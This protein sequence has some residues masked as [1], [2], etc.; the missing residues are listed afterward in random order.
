[1]SAV[2]DLFAI[3]RAA[4]SDENGIKKRLTAEYE[5]SIRKKIESIPK[6]YKEDVD[7]ILKMTMSVIQSMDFECFA[8]KICGIT[9]KLNSYEF[10]YNA[11]SSSKLESIEKAF[12]F[13]FLQELKLVFAC[14]DFILANPSKYSEKIYR[15][16]M[17]SVDNDIL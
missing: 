15:F 16:K 4:F 7:K 17:S 2:S 1:M 12:A 11:I 14:I 9:F 13:S 10:V 6:G 8:K 5:N 3:L